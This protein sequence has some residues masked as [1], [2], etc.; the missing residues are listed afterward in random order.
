MKQ[1]LTGNC[2]HLKLSGKSEGIRGIL[3]ILYRFHSILL[4][5][6]ISLLKMLDS[7][8]CFSINV[9]EPLEIQ[10]S[11]YSWD[12][13]VAS[14]TEIIFVF[15]GLKRVMHFRCWIEAELLSLISLKFSFEPFFFFPKWTKTVNLWGTF[16]LTAS[17]MILFGISWPGAQLQT[18]TIPH[19]TLKSL[20]LLALERNLNFGIDLQTIL[21]LLILFG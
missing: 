14:F 6:L 4:R 12:S 7:K 2:R 19:I 11:T 20:L 21:K 3:G 10:W 17:H 1:M 9:S 8:Y 15:G 18:Y 13:F 5:V 16:L